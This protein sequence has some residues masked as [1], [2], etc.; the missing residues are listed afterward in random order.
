MA[1]LSK[2]SRGSVQEKLQW[3]FG[4]Y[5]INKDGHITKK[6]MVDVVNSIY[7]MLG[8]NTEPQVNELSGV[9]HVN[10]IFPVSAQPKFKICERV[11]SAIIR[12]LSVLFCFF[13]L[14][15]I[16]ICFCTVD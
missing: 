3:I 6:E 13:F 4:L 12:I 7:E 10:K 2:V 16:N 9:E 5:D 1:I 11:K 8:R 15:L 14:F